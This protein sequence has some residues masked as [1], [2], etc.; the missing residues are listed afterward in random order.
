MIPVWQFVS[1]PKPR[2]NNGA[3]SGR[4][5]IRYV[6]GRI[7]GNASSVS[8]RRL[9]RGGRRPLEHRNRRRR[10]RS[11]RLLGHLCVARD[12]PQSARTPN[13]CRATRQSQKHPRHLAR[14]GARSSVHGRGCRARPV[15]DAVASSSSAPSGPKG[16]THDFILEES[17][18]VSYACTSALAEMYKL[19]PLCVARR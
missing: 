12:P 8:S 13:V 15:L 1:I 14:H 10:C 4:P 3:S 18:D 7:A 19:S 5:S 2:A 9:R 17:D 6:E 16:L 11:A